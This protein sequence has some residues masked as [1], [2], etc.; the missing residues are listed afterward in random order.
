MRCILLRG[1]AHPVA[2]SWPL[3]SVTT[4]RVRGNSG[5]YLRSHEGVNIWNCFSICASVSHTSSLSSMTWRIASRTV[6]IIS[7]R[8]FLSTAMTFV[9]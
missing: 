7:M 2:C 5:P 6:H 3:V 8:R 4:A 1:Y 9:L